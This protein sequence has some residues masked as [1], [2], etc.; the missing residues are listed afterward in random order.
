MF[1][2]AGKTR[3][4]AIG[5][6]SQTLI[7]SYSIYVTCYSLQA[8]VDRDLVAAANAGNVELVA[9]LLDKGVDVNSSKDEKGCTPLVAACNSGST[10][11]VKLLLERGADVSMP[12]KQ[13]GKEVYMTPLGAAL[14]KGHEEVAA[15]LIEHGADV[16]AVGVEL[17]VGED[18]SSITHL[19]VAIMTGLLRSTKLLLER[20]ADVNTKSETNG[21]YFTPLGVA[22]SNGLEEI[23]ALLIEHGA[24][25]NAV[26]LEGEVKDNTASLTPLTVAAGQGLQHATKL[27]LE[28]GAEIDTKSEIIGITFTPLGMALYLSY[29][30]VAVVLIEHGAD[31][32]AVGAKH[33]VGEVTISGTP[34]MLAAGKGFQHAT[35]L[36]LERGAEVDREAEAENEGKSISATALMSPDSAEVAQLLLEYGAEIDFQGS[37]GGCTALIAASG[38]GCYEVAEF[39]LERG[40]QVDLQDSNGKTALMYAVVKD[41]DIPDKDTVGLA[42]L[43]LQH[44]ANPQLEDGKGKTAL[45]LA[46][47]H[48]DTELIE[49]LSDPAKASAPRDTS[50][51]TPRPRTERKKE[52]ITMFG[53]FKA[54]FTSLGT[55]S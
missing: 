43:L 23:A 18:Y 50:Q 48:W 29:E 54:L 11:L 47:E 1:A 40:A 21:N 41:D 8:G 10:E 33:K 32:N 19:M 13:T 5:T 7:L 30:E 44:G 36:L 14:G 9:S 26:G 34:L 35:K 52:P 45:A 22:L 16:N 46:V 27:L 51:H 15:L 17:R 39:L 49:L 38:Q 55:R 24:D 28:C 25:V 4:V 6:T 3:K 31:I 2:N 42:R 37:R 53:M 20:S 12:A